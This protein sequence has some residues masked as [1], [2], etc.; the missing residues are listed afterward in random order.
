M[1]LRKNRLPLK[2][3]I[4]TKLSKLR[5]VG[6]LWFGKELASRFLLELGWFFLLPCAFM[7]H[8]MNLR[9]VPV[10][11][12]HIGHLTTELDTFVKAQ[13]L[14]LIP[15]ATYFILAP[16]NKVANKYLLTYWSKYFK[17]VRKPWLCFLLKMITHR[18][19][20]CY[21]GGLHCVRHFG[22]QEIYRI[23]QLW[24]T[25]PPV[26]TLSAEDQVWAERSLLELGIPQDCWFVAFHV[27]EGGFLPYNESIQAHRNASIENAIPA[28]QEIV[29]RGGMV[30]RM[31]DASMMALPP[32]SGIIDYAKHPLK[33]ERMDVILC[34]KAK[35]FLGCTSGLAFLSTVFGVPIAHANM[36]PIETLGLRRGDLS[37]PKLIWD[38][39]QGRYLTF[40][41]LFNSESG[42]YFFTHQY[43]NAG[44]EGHENNPQEI[45]DLV[46]EML[47]RLNG[48]YIETEMDRMLQKRY[49]AFLKP[50]HYSFAAASKIGQAFLRKH[51]N[52]FS[53][54]VH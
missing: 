10:I 40:E 52:L 37:I 30:I 39:F 38:K 7:L 16:A 44:L 5:T 17:I 13:Q 36:I 18:Y 21:T 8:R 32:M 11:Y 45:V 14:E 15:P 12:Q 19:L 23:N 48:I 41:E 51:Q 31:G 24:D 3:F 2:D 49:M 28:M 35:F 53:D 26:L 46:V 1:A 25:R 54:R 29:K 33:S 34:A 20:A 43:K 22:T 4:V 27:R 42:G 6:F 47:D 9:C 50:G